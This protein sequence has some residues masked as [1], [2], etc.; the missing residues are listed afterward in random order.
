MNASERVEVNR[1]NPL[2][3]RIDCEKCRALFLPAAL[4]RLCERLLT[5]EGDFPR[6]LDAL[7][8]YFKVHRDGLCT[9]KSSVTVFEFVD[10]SFGFLFPFAVN[11]Q[12]LCQSLNCF[13][14]EDKGQG[15]HQDLWKESRASSAHRQP[16]NVLS[17]NV[18]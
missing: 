4:N 11:R 1:W 6:A 18:K 16:S 14:L 2:A 3:T 7:G 9:S 12:Y 17:G 13:P 8:G 15:P 5:G 10:G